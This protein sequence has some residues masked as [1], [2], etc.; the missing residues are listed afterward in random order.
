LA[1]VLILISGLIAA[2]TWIGHYDPLSRGSIGYP[3]PAGVGAKVVDVSYAISDAPRIFRIPAV[4]GMTF[5][6]RFSISNDGPAAITIKDVGDVWEHT[7][8]AVNRR[9]VRIMTDAYATP[10][11][12]PWIAFRPFTLA[13][14]QEGAIEMEATLKG[15]MDAAETLGWSDENITYTVF[16]FTRQEMF[17]PDVD[18]TLVGG[19]GSICSRS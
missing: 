14:G 5:R 3:P 9:P 17:S 2:A 12:S 13:P 18:V 7:G 15:C 1:V 10:T 4:T 11:G 16:G 19:P 6:Y 8:N